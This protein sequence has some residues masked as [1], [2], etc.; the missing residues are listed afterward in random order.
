MDCDIDL[1]YLSCEQGLPEWE[2]GISL[3]VCFDPS[4][5]CVLEMQVTYKI[6][7]KFFLDSDLTLS[8]FINVA[9]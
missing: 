8:C 1:Q 9:N 6:G 4:A 2:H 3:L 5:T 7:F